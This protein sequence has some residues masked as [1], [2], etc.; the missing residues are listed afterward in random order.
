MLGGAGL[1]RGVTAAPVRHPSPLLDED[2]EHHPGLV[3]ERRGGRAQLVRLAT[4]VLGNLSALLRDQF[5]SVRVREG[6]GGVPWVGM[7][8]TV[9]PRTWRCP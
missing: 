9:S 7:P 5:S 1:P 6:G 4:Q 3:P 8:R 2:D